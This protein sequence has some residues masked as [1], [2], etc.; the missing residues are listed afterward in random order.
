LKKIGVRQLQD[1]LKILGVDYYKDGLYYYKLLEYPLILKEI[2]FEESGKILDIG[3]GKSFLPLY[4]LYRGFET[5]VVDN[6]EFYADFDKFYRQILDSRR[7]MDDENMSIIWGNFQEID[8][9]TGYFDF[10]TAISTLEHFKFSGDMQAAMKINALLKKGGRFIVTLPFSQAGTREKFFDNNGHTYF[11][12]DYELDCVF[13]RIV[14]PSKLKLKYFYIIGERFPSLGKF[15][16]FKMPFAK[17]KNTWARLF[18]KLFW[19]VYYKGKDRKLPQFK[20]P[21]VII[22]VLEK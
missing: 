14:E 17:R 16:F 4:F 11:Q 20:Y 9:P 2:D 22:M 6:G 7:F 3:C 13:K 21:G 1:F 10:I 18:S 19:K 12:R 15:F 8:F 5:W